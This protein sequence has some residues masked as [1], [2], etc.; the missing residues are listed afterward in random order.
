MGFK[1]DEHGNECRIIGVDKEQCLVWLQILD[2]D[3]GSLDGELRIVQESTLHASPPRRKIDSR[4]IELRATLEDL[5]H[6][7]LARKKDLQSFE[8]GRDDRMVRLKQHKSL[9][10]LDDF[11]AGRITHY[12]ED[13]YGPPT[14]VSFEDAKP[15]GGTD[16]RDKLKLLTLF[17]RTNGDL[18]WGLNEYSDGSGINTT[19]FPCTSYN[20]AVGVAAKLFAKHKE[21]A[22][23]PDDRTNPHRNWVARASKYDIVIAP[24]YLQRLQEQ[25]DAAKAK[26]IAELESEIKTLR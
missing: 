9:R 14:I 10:R 6:Q 12:V 18:E 25:E 11:I 26:R 20:E 4:I 17:G 16:R 13:S 19:V 15:V 7:I 8:D 22:M 5:C 23:A 1:Y 3:G 2:E 24:D 21:R